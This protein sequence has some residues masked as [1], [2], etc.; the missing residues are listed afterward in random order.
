MQ[1]LVESWAQGIN[2]WVTLVPEGPAWIRDGTEI[3]RNLPSSK[4]TELRVNQKEGS[5]WRFLHAL[6]SQTPA[7]GRS[8]PGD[9]R[10]GIVRAFYRAYSVLIVPTIMRPSLVT[11]RIGRPLISLCFTH[12]F[13]KVVEEMWNTWVSVSF[14]KCSSSLRTSLFCQEDWLTPVH[15]DP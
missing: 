9:R 4:N 10:V 12:V 14:I 5:A 13:L 8:C 11:A 3:G 15:L 1:S 2:T 7:T 6:Q